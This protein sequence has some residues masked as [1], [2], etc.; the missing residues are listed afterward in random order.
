MEKKF[1][2]AQRLRE[3]LDHYGI[4]QTDLAARTGISKSSLSHYLKGDWEGKQD[5]IYKISSA[6][7]ISSAWLM[8]VDCPMLSELPMENRSFAKPKC[9]Q[10]SAP[11]SDELFSELTPADREADRLIAQI[12]SKIR[13]ERTKRGMSQT[14][15]AKMLGVSQVMVSKWEC[16]MYNFTIESLTDILC[17]LGISMDIRFRSAQAETIA[18]IKV[19]G[20]RPLPDH[21]LWVRFND[22]AAKVFD[23]KP[24][25]DT[26]AFAPLRDPALFSQVYI[27]YGIPV[28]ND[29][30]IDIAPEKLYADGVAADS[31]A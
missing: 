22:G 29:G 27:D 13:E 20:V 10:H 26:P 19:C 25:L 15:F 8:G 7:G 9:D 21:R 4:R 1:T 17:K 28:W 2:L 6:Y 23:F 14:E 31:V 18:D 24:L 16:C 5:V 30:E 12:S 11:V 3:L